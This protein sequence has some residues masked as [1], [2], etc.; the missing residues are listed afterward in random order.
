MYDS[1]ILHSKVFVHSRLIEAPLHVAVV[2][3]LARDIRPD[4]AMA[5]QSDQITIGDPPGD[6]LRDITCKP[7]SSATVIPGRG[8]VS[9]FNFPQRP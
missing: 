4:H 5:M 1:F 3:A 9:S 7:I 6:R 2:T 8:T